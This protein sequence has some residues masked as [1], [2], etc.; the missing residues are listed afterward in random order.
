LSL[1]ILMVTLNASAGLSSQLVGR[2]K[3]YKLLPMM[4]LFVGIGAVVALALSAKTM[5]TVQFEI[6]LFLVGV[7]FGPTAPLTQ[8]VLQNTVSIHHLG[9]AI[10]T[11]NFVRTLMSTILVEV[12][13]AIVLAAVPI[14]ASGDTLGQRALAGTSVAAFTVV[15]F[16]A[17]ITLSIA[18]LAMILVQEKPLEST[19]STAR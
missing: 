12:F 5:T 14:G 11:M 2:V 18:Q 10:G 1:M 6:I 9:A 3:H 7:G 15:F 4:F 16:A 8:V 19:I 13:G 17:A